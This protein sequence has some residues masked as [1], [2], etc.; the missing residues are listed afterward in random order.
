MQRYSRGFGACNRQKA[1][2]V[3]VSARYSAGMAYPLSQVAAL[4]FIV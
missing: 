1:R 4:P 3:K 2:G